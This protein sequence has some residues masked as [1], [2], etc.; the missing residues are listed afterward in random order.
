M[1]FVITYSYDFGL[2]ISPVMSQRSGTVC[3]GK[4]KMYIKNLHLRADLFM[5]ASAALK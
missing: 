3:K 4:Y 2:I 5:G 1:D